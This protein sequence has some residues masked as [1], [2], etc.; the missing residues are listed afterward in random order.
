MVKTL[1]LNNQI[2]DYNLKVS[3]RTKS[4]RLTV[5]YDGSINITIPSR[6]EDKVAEA[7][8]IKKYEWIIDKIA[9]FKKNPKTVIVRHTTKEIKEY[10]EKANTLACMR[11]EHFN[12]FYNLSWKNISIKNT[13]SR[14]GSCSKKGNLNFN[15]K[16]ALL[17]PHL[18]DY[19]VV[20][21]LCHLGELNHSQ[22]FWNLVSKT[23]PH[24]K[25]L[26]RQLK[27]II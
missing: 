21:E 20:H 10:K 7:F 13:K 9:H 5:S 4:I 26:R 23:L 24:H 2:I 27:E 3:S 16:I 15:Y 11:L 8:I 19:I 25:E 1:T 18:A 12:Q 14:W 17:P 6:V 22:N